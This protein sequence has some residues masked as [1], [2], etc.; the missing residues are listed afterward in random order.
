LR[1]QASRK[2]GFSCAVTVTYKMWTYKAI[3]ICMRDAYG[4]HIN[5]TD[6]ELTTDAEFRKRLGNKLN[7][8]AAAHGRPEVYTP[9]RI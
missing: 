3:V 4:A 5:S 7:E 9:D 8:F 2:S 6:G 1:K